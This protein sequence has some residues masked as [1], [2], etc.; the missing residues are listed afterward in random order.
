M[1]SARVRAGAGAGSV[2][3][4]HRLAELNEL[5]TA[6]VAELRAELDSDPAASDPRGVARRQPAAEDRQRRVE[7]A[8]YALTQIEA[9]NMAAA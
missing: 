2:R 9:G 5:A 7:Q 8:Q 3:R 6:K 4:K 1:D